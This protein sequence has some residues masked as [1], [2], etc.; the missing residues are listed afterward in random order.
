MIARHDGRV[1]LVAGAIPGER[2]RARVTRVARGVAH[3][4]TVAIEEPSPDRR[5]V[6]ADPLCGGCL[7]SHIAYP[8]QL[9]IKGEVIADAFKR[10]GRIDLPAAVDGCRFTRGRLS[11]ARAA[12]RPR[13]AP[14]ILP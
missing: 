5:A 8:R 7:Y 10:I 13:L 1:V 6:A 11:H 14:R 3:A 2:V 12:A 9:A 4:E